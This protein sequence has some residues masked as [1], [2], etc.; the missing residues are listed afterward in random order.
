M[1]I[2]EETGLAT[3]P[4]TGTAVFQTPGAL[5]S[6]MHI[7]P[8]RNGNATNDNKQQ[9]YLLK[10]TMAYHGFARYSEYGS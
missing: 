2:V 5:T 3:G 10:T 6:C 4:E 9:T 1:H 8:Q 7:F